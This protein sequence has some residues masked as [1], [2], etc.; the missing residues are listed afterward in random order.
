MLK[1]ENEQLTSFGPIWS[2]FELGQRLTL[3]SLFPLFVS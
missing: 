2:Q 1:N 3:Q